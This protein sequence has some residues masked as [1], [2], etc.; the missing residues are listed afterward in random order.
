[1]DING[2]IISTDQ[3][4]YVVAEI[5]GNHG[6]YLPNAINLIKRAK[7]A[8]ADAVKTQCYDPDS[9]TLDLNKP[10]FIV[11]GGLWHGRTL[12]DLYTKAHTPPDW[13]RE[14]YRVA[15]SEGITIFSSV[16]DKRGVDLLE[17]LD[18]PVYKI[19]SF[20]IVDI[21]LIKY[22]AQTKKPMIISTG[23]ATDREIL[24]ARWA[25]KGKALF[26]H[27]VSSYPTMIGEANLGRPGELRHLLSTENV[28]LSDHSLGTTIPIAATVL[29][30]VLIEKHLKL[31]YHVD[32]EDSVFS[33]TPESFAE[34]VKAVQN[35]WHAMRS[36]A[37]TSESRQF[38]R[39]LYAVKDIAK[40]E[41]YTEE[42][43]RSIRPGY[44]LSPKMLGSLLGK[45]SKRSWKRGDPLS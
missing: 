43:I 14:L 31:E 6:G 1:M 19:A 15:R 9:M 12:Y 16:F 5:S 22:V 21:P 30:T 39:S 37:K 35:I 2:R 20:E 3:P 45:K 23:M 32:T 24:D 8:G 44:G 17:N 13:H 28:G 40:G 33:E 10:D 34:M 29:G 27:C 7:K 11:Q 36:Q 26:L 4:P 42:N 38:R 18:C 41:C 25:S